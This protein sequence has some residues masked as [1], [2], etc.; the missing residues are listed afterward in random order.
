MANRV[1]LQIG[2][3]LQSPAQTLVNTVNCV[4]IMG[5]GLALEFKRRFPGMYKDYRRRCKNGEMRLGEPYLFRQLEIPWI[6]NFP[7]KGH[8]RPTSRLDDI[9]DGL[10]FLEKHYKEWGITS[11]AFPAL[12]CQNGQLDWRVVIPIMHKRLSKFEIPIELYAPQGVSP[13]EISDIINEKFAQINVQ[14]T[15]SISEMIKPT[16][17]SLVEILSIIEKSGLR[18]PIGRL[19]F[20]K[21]AYFAK[22]QGLP[23]ELKYRLGNTG[24][25]TAAME[26]IISRLINNGLIREEKFGRVRA[27]KVGPSYASTRM[28]YESELEKW[29]PINERVAKLIIDVGTR[30]MGVAATIHFIAI[31][32]EQKSGEKPTKEDIINQLHKWRHRK[33]FSLNEDKI[34]QIMQQLEASLLIKLT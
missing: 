24:P 32:H 14:Y 30:S 17:R 27:I 9:L 19:A 4:G 8:W 5:K 10:D 33:R 7:T 21:I 23:F 16:W 2:D 18:H 3:V 28:I 34:S 15:E 31:N 20:T 12:G 1:K 22:S 26:K 6:L 13:D 25:H 11:I 29:V